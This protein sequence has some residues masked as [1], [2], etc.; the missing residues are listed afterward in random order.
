[1]LCDFSVRIRVTEASAAQQVLDKTVQWY[2]IGQRQLNCNHMHMHAAC[3]MPPAPQ[4][5]KS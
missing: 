4:A 1:M 2:R 3:S 5:A